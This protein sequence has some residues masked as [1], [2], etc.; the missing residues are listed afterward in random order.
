VQP[1]IAPDGSIRLAGYRPPA[2]EPNTV[3]LNFEGGSGDIP[4]YSL[5]DLHRCLEKGDAEFFRSRFAGKVVLIGTVLD[6][7]DRKITSKRY[8]TTPETPAQDRCA[9]SRPA[10]GLTFTRDAIAGVYIHATAI[11]NLMR[12]EAITEFGSAGHMAAG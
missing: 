7:E 2:V 12:R 11:N 4:T 9:L 6:V 1:E 10:Q 5:A 8:A 3:T